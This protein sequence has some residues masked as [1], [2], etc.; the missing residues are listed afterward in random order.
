MVVHLML[1]SFHQ[2]LGC[3]SWNCCCTAVAAVFIS[4]VHRKVAVAVLQERVNSVAT[5]TSEVNLV[6]KWSYAYNT[7][8]VQVL[9][10]TWPDYQL[11]G[12][13]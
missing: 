13:M 9:C 1:Y 3:L 4:K 2:A 6:Y 8:P 11:K 10:S 7:E 5:A 12:C